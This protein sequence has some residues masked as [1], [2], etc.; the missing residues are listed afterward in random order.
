MHLHQKIYVANYGPITKDQEGRSL[1]IHHIDGNHSNNAIENLKAITIQEHF[2][3]H[4]AQGDYNACLRMARRMKLSPKETS[5]LASKAAM[6][7]VQEGTHHFL[8]SNINETRLK[9]GTH[10][11]L[12]SEFQKKNLKI[13][14]ENGTHHLLSGNIQRNAAK[15]NLAL[16]KH[17]SQVVRTCSHCNKTGKGNAMLQ[18]HFEKCKKKL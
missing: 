1:E 7:R 11:F 2:D 18:Y 3:I 14:V 13:R 12:D 15:K 9:N 4:L 8:G 17:I 5:E 10:L 6:K 16:G